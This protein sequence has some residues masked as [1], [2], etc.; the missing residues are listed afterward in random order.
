MVNYSQTCVTNPADFP[1]P[2]PIQTERLV[3]RPPQKGDGK[4]VFHAIQESIGELEPFSPWVRG[5]KFSEEICE[6]ESVQAAEKFRLRHD[7]RFHVFDRSTAELVGAVG[8]SWYDWKAREFEI[9]FWTRTS[10]ARRNYASE[11]THALA[12]YAFEKLQ[13]KRV[14]LKCHTNNSAARSLILDLGFELES[15]A[16]GLCHFSMS[17]PSLLRPARSQKA[18][19][20]QT[21]LVIDFQKKTAQGICTLFFQPLDQPSRL[22]LKLPGY[23]IHEVLCE[24]QKCDF[25]LWGEN[26][27]MQVP[28]SAKSVTFRYQVRSSSGL[29]IHSS[30]AFTGHETNRWMPCHMDPSQ[31]ASFQLNVKVPSDMSLVCSSD[32]LPFS[33]YLFGFA[34]GKF[35]SS[36]IKDEGKRYLFYGVQETSNGLLNR[37]KETPSMLKF[38][39]SKTGISYPKKTYT[40]VLVPDDICQEKNGFSIISKKALD[41]ILEDPKHDWIIIHELAHQWFGNSITCRTW[42]DLWLN[43]GFATFLVACYKNKTWGETEFDREMELLKS[44]H[45]TAVKSNQDFRLGDPRSAENFD[46][47]QSLTYSKAALFLEDLRLRLGDALFWRAIQDYAQE[48]WMGSVQGRDL[49]R[50]FL[51]VDP[52]LKTFLESRIEGSLLF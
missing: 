32:E 28:A 24:N 18:I 50:A 40:Q 51:K 23:E 11:S 12:K 16:Q 27:W 5:R 38:L 42:N 33:A 1:F 6:E 7:L 35:Q 15:E 10:R 19:R 22:T 43:E 46:L 47:T 48:N 9:G 4:A 37:F 20:Y 26:F 52:S 41:P 13:A 3:I 36:E 21:D 8:Y 39:E 29:T 44:R 45:K 14:F 49:A 34:I 30:Y 17:N 25:Q 2:L 31:K